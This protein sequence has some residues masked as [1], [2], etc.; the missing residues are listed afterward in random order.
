MQIANI[1]LDKFILTVCSRK[2]THM[3]PNS[4]PIQVFGYFYAV[5]ITLPISCKLLCLEANDFVCVFSYSI[6]NLII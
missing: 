1:C 2:K 6:G 4:E 5:Y 3:C